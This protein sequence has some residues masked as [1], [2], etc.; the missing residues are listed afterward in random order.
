MT[1]AS[2]GRMLL[3]HN[4]TLPST[5]L[6]ALSRAEFAQI[7]IDGLANQPGLA[8]RAVDNPHWIIAITFGA[9]RSPQ[10]VG[11]LCLEALGA[12]RL[13][14]LD[15]HQGQRPYILALGGTKVTPAQSDSPDAIQPGD[16]GVD[17]VET[18]EPASF[19][20]G[21]D[22]DSLSATKAANAVF[23]LETQILAGT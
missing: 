14:Q 11:Q 13:P 12:A 18:L 6:P 22:W 4:F 16:W 7:F 5:L 10:Q 2:L 17:L 19:L 20:A 1:A 8:C 15:R 21:I 23:K 9:A 3:S